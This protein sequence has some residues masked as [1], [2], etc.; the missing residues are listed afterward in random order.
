M[1]ESVPIAR[2]TY[3]RTCRFAKSRDRVDRGNALRQKSIGNELGQLRRPEIRRQDA[4]A[5]H[6]PRINGDELLD[7]RESFR[8]LFATNQNAIGS[9]QVRYRRT[10]G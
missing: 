6:P 2:A 1:R 10:L 9:F 7:G 8:G 3:M 4:L 5:G